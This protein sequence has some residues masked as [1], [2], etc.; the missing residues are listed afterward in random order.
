MISR[1]IPLCALLILGAASAEAQEGRPQ[2]VVLDLGFAPSS[3][4]ADARAIGERF[5]ESVRANA[6]LELISNPLMEKQRTTDGVLGLLKEKA[7]RGQ[8]YMVSGSLTGY[9][10][11]TI[12]YIMNVADV[13]NAAGIVH[14]ERNGKEVGPFLAASDTMVTQ[15]AQFIAQARGRK[16]GRG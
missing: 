5:R 8:V 10:D 16:R 1:L 11:G 13:S 9:Q 14:L 12:R 6:G 15:M 3:L 2:I 7:G 4:G